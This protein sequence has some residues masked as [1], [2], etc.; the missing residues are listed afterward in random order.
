MKITLRYGR[1]DRLSRLITIAVVVVLLVVC[2]SLFATSHGAT[3]LAA[4][5]TSVAV[6][7][8]ALCMLSWPRRIIIDDEKVEL[9]CLVESSY[10]Q[11]SSIVDVETIEGRGLAG[12]IPLLG[13]FG[14]GGYYGFWL[15]LA[16]R[17]IYRTYV[18]SRTN[19]VVIHTSHRR[20]L[21]SCAAP[22]MLRSL[23]LA[24]KARSPKEE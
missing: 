12:K 7:V 5:T 20:Y 9:R 2:L 13:I 16:T 19:C 10:I 21:V 17:K 8:V 23:I 1:R 6:A 11:M 3:Y 4:W 14:F 15:D 18:T 24:T 22:E